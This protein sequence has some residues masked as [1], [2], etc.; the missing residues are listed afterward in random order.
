MAVDVG[1][2][3]GAFLRARRGLVSPSRVGLQ[4]DASRRVSGLRR[5]EVALLAEVSTD[6]YVRLE[7]GRERRPSE[8]V[9]NAI[10]R[11]L[12]L[13]EPTTA[14]L[15][16]VAT[17]AARRARS[18]ARPEV[19]ERLRQLMEHFL[20]MPACV[21]GPASDILAANSLA[22]ALYSGFTRFGNLLHMI[23]LDPFAH[24]FYVDWDEV[25]ANA[26][27]NLRAQTGQFPDDPGIEEIIGE[28]SVRSALFAQIWARQEVRPRGAEV[29]RICH[30]RI[31]RLDLHYQAFTV[32]GAPG[33]RL[34]VYSAAPD[35]AAAAGLSALRSLSGVTK[36]GAPAD[37]DEPL[38][39]A[40]A[41]ETRR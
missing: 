14:Y 22:K 41:K 21:V 7:Q 4:D 20:D 19:D 25:A 33:Q 10:A 1:N 15:F 31:G 37:P 8:Q 36:S 40:E 2:E 32:V 26:V 28:L 18:V 34:F 24:G 23:F 11:A 17:P 12:L 9:L 5:E 29:K 35:S 39:T 3:L 16:R 6:Y 38:K 27:A 30:P 13:D